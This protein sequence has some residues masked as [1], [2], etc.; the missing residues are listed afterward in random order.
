MRKTGSKKAVKKAEKVPA[1]AV[2][3]GKSATGRGQRGPSKEGD[4]LARSEES[5]FAEAEKS[6]GLVTTKTGLDLTEKVRDLLR[7]AREQGHLT[8][9]DV[10][11]ALPD[12]MVTAEDLDQVH[13]KLRAMEIDIIDP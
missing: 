11:D 13:T 10:N 6:L 9:E 8:Y 4:S 5:S 2:T 7:L 12:H 3:N 1:S